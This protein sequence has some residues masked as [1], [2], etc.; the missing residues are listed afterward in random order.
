VDDD[1]DRSRVCSLSGSGGETGCRTACGSNYD[2]AGNPRFINSH[3][4]FDFPRMMSGTFQ[5]DLAYGF[6]NFDNFGI[7]FLSIFQ[8][9]TL[10]GWD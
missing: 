7:S 2:L 8:V 1:H 4:P 10:E 3:A 9:I 5:S 6:I